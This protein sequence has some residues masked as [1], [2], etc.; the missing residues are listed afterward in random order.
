MMVRRS[1]GHPEA[2]W[3]RLFRLAEHLDRSE[4]HRAEPDAA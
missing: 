1:Q 3:R 2:D 4:R